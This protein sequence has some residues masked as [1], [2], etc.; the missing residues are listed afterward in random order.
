MRNIYLPIIILGLLISGLVWFS[1][2]QSNSY[3]QIISSL[4]NQVNSVASSVNSI[5]KQNENT[6]T[7]NQTTSSTPKT[8]EQ[9]ITGAVEKIT[10]SVVSIIISKKV[11]SMD[12]T[13]TNPFSDNPFLK[14]F[15]FQI[16]EYHQKDSTKQKIG[17]GT[18]LIVD[19][20]G[21]VLTNN[22]V[23]S[24]TE[25]EY[26]IV[27]QDSTQKNAKV[28]FTDE[29]DDVALLKID[30]SYPHTASLGDSSKLK[31]GQTVIAVGN[32]LGEYDNTVSVGIVSGLNR[33]IEATDENSTALEKLHG[34]I[35]T[36]VSVNPGNSGGP[37]TDLNGD[38]I[39]I[40][41]AQ[42]VGSN[43]INF[44]LPINAIKKTIENKISK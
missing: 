23:V 34:V 32:A 20:R 17:A 2:Y 31:I 25:A 8:Q 22:H 40:N 43:N 37:L 27:L 28:I 10:P 16:P 14:D 30:G 7:T 19:A 9:L 13:Y 1:L 24:D 36:D 42:A 5:S 38:V 3:K 12:I 18:G 35:Q 6:L 41:V 11:P 21:Y 15:G 39:G 44:S 26:T 33:D 29:Q 4:Q